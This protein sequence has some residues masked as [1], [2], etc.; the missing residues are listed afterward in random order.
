MS[1]LV[2][3]RRVNS[4]LRFVDTFAHAF[5]VAFNLLATVIGLT[6]SRS[7][8]DDVD[9]AMLNK[10]Y[11]SDPVGEKMQPRNLHRHTA[12]ADYTQ[13]R[14]EMPESNDADAPAPFHAAHQRFFKKDRNYTAAVALHAM[15]NNLV[16]IHQTL[17]VTPAM[18]AGITDRLWEIS[19]LV[20]V[21][22]EWEAQQDSEPIFDGT[23]R[24]R[25]PRA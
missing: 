8:V 17:K 3:D 24:N 14:R 21:L 19:D 6:P 13:Y 11:D 2:G 4:A 9:Y 5:P 7:I 16:R 15:F 25:G 20:R 10:I 22:E 12:K 1:W 18:A 23:N